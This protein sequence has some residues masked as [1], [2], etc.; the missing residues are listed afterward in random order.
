MDTPTTPIGAASSL[1]Q[2]LIV[3]LPPAFLLLCLLNIAMVWLILDTVEHQSA[4]R[5][6]I[7]TRV[8]DQCL[9]VRSPR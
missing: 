7:L 2:S 4:Q 9:T 8:I 1:A 6:E 3:A 5:L